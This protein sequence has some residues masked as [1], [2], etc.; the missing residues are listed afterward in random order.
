MRIGFLHHPNDPYTEVRMKYFVAAGHQ[1]WSIVF[2]G[3]EPQRALPGAEVITLS[4]QWLNKIPFGR[5]L[6]HA[7]ELSRI[8]ANL[9]LDALYVI[10][11]LNSFYLKASRA[12]KTF[13]EIQGSDVL[14]S[15]NKMPLLKPFYR[16]YWKF[17][18]GITQ[19]SEQARRKAMDYMPVGMDNQ[20]IEIGVDFSLF[21]PLIP[22]G[23]MREK[24]G[25]GDRP[26]VFHSRG[27]KPLYN[28][29]TIMKS[30]PIVAKEI[31]EVCLVFCGNEDQ[32]SEAGK[33]VLSESTCRANIIFCGWVDHD[34]EMPSFIA[35][36]DVSVS[37]PLTD[38]SPFSVYEA[39]AMKIPV[40]VSNLPWLHDKFEAENHLLTV[41]TL[42]H[43]QLGDSIL[44]ILQ[45]KN[46]P[47]VEAAYDQVHQNVNMTTENAKLEQMI[48]KHLAQA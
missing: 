10:S 42:D 24:L 5:R 31:P 48:L 9:Q 17:A 41:P 43:N 34:L 28:L 33:K 18:A 47:N 2:P 15:P 39:M 36:A 40:I 6:S 8:T 29:E 13:L 7:R 1:V 27:I 16:K 25:L 21:N 45:K 46:G 22:K 37:M 26:I 35:D 44:T 30:V 19:D 32:L 38:S 3:Y 20:T 4:K 23:K 11:A 12:K 14:Y